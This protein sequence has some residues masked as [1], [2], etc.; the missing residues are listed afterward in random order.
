MPAK[1]NR[2]PVLCACGCGK[3]LLIGGSAGL[4]AL[5]VRYYYDL[6][7]EV[8]NPNYM[9]GG[10]KRK[11]RGGMPDFLLG[12]A[13]NTITSFGTSG[14]TGQL[15]GLI[16]GQSQVSPDVTVQPIITGST[17]YFA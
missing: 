6:N 13:S 1:I 16:T 15:V 8:K 4:E 10:K 3:S 7:D 14:G 2:Q 12:S 17:K 9:K 11:L 5:P